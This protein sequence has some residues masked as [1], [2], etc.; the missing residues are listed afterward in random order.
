LKYLSGIGITLSSKIHIDEKISFDGSVLIT[1][2]KK[3]H[4]LSRRMA[5]RIFVTEEKI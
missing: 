5:E 4:L 2:E 1:L 3:K